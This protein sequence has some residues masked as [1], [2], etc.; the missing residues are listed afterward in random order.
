MNSKVDLD[1]SILARTA[2]TE[3]GVKLLFIE[4]PETGVV[5]LDAKAA[6]ILASFITKEFSN[7]HPRN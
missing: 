2:R 6:L 7:E 5:V 1:I 3:E 4:D